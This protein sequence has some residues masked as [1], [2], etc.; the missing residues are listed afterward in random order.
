MVN[1]GLDRLQIF[2]LGCSTREAPRLSSL[3][4][5]V[6]QPRITLQE[7]EAV[8]RRA[9]INGIADTARRSGVL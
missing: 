2:Q 1:E 3:P 8:A 6:H 9:V 4:R 5:G 7:L